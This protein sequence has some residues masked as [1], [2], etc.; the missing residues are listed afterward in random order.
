MDY[1]KMKRDGWKLDRWGF[2][3]Q[4]IWA[5]IELIS[6][7]SMAYELMR[8]QFGI[9]IDGDTFFLVFAVLFIIRA[10]KILMRPPMRQE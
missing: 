4:Y 5:V 3:F 10:V 1:F 7:P 8:I 6:L 2:A 9:S